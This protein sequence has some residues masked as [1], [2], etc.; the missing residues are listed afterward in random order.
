MRPYKIFSIGCTSLSFIEMDGD[1]E[2]TTVDVAVV[3]VGGILT[4]MVLARA[5]DA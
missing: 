4:I 1:L 3:T 5:N 2:R